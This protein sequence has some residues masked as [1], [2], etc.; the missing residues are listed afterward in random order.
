METNKYLNEERYQK[1]KSKITRIA[2]IVL[3]IGLL[4]GGGLIT[5]GI[6]KQ[7]KI[8]EKYSSDNKVKI[9]EQIVA[10]RQNLIRV[11]DELEKDSKYNKGSIRLIEEVLDSSFNHCAFDEAK[12]DIY[13]SKYCSLKNELSSLNEFKK[14]FDSSE[15]IPFY[16]FGGFIIVASMMIAFAIYMSTKQRE[17]LAFN[18]QQIMPVAKEGIDEISPS[19]GKVAKEITKGIKEGIKDDKE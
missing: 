10:E 9:Q 11:K 14:S 2:V 5:A 4:A 1:T 18:A 8:N 7:S 3:L 6:I 16:M 19:L 17:I 12:N 15:S 13:T